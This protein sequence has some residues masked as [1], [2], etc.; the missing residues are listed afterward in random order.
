MTSRPLFISV[1][2]STVI[3]GPIDQVGMGEG[4]VDGDVLELGPGA[5]AERPAA[6]GQHDAR[7]TLGA[8]DRPRRHWC[9]AQCSES[10]G[11]ISAP[12]VARTRCTTGPAAMSDSL[13]ARARRRPALEGGERDRQAGEADDAVDD[14][15]GE[16][17][18]R[19]QRVGA[20]E[21]LGAGRHRLL[22]LGG[23]VGV[24]DGDDLGA[25]LG[26]LLGQQRRPRSW[27]PTRRSG[28]GR[29]RPG[30][31]RA[32]GCRSSRWTR[33]RRRSSSELGVQEDDR[34][35]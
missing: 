19:G 24:G 4:V 34:T 9:T 8:G 31:R 23:T 28:S 26:G 20:G 32:S 16:R 2:E 11:M 30:R 18:D 27:P 33:R 29:A 1:D 3:F 17:G 21:H 10:T 6:G 14:D 5:A 35:R 25:E 13:L 12:G 7:A 22:Q 15:V